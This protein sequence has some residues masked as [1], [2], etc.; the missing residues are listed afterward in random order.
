MPNRNLLNF[1]LVW[2]ILDA[3]WRIIMSRRFQICVPKGGSGCL[4]PSYERPKLTL[5]S[6]KNAY[7]RR[8]KEQARS[9]F[10]KYRFQNKSALAHNLWEAADSFWN[11]YFEKLWPYLFSPLWLPQAWN[12]ALRRR[13]RLS[14]ELGLY[15]WGNRPLSAV[16]WLLLS[17][18]G[19]CAPARWM[20]P[21]VWSP[22][23]HVH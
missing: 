4:R 8:T 5:I 23:Q 9:Q 7:L 3:T 19:G 20:S 22:Q 14:T 16:Q 11:L 10:S 21:I 6:K 1:L 13:C 17:A 2:Y 18:E 12:Q 15:L